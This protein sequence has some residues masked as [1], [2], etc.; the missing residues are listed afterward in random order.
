VFEK[1]AV[2]TVNGVGMPTKG[3]CAQQPESGGAQIDF[4]RDCL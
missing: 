2:D 1:H 4:A 3:E